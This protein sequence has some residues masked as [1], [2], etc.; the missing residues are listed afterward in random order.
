[1]AK[2]APPIPKL[3]PIPSGYRRAKANEVTK[4]VLQFARLAL[5]DAL[6]IGKHQTTVIN[7]HTTTDEEKKGAKGKTAER[8]IIAQ[9]E[10]HYDN[11]PSGGKGDPYWHPGISILVPVKQP[12]NPFPVAQAGL[13][14]S[15][16]E[17]AGEAESLDTEGTGF[18]GSDEDTS[19]S[20]FLADTLPE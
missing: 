3:V 15:N 11:H 1:M 6:P 2:K 17:F 10:Y 13:P 18:L 14:T 4:P 19:D 7:G 5:E 16:N 8:T 12:I 9:T 20:S